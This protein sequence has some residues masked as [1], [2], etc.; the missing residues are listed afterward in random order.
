[1]NK[2][3]ILRYLIF[4]ILLLQ[5]VYGIA[6]EDISPPVLKNA[7]IM[8][9]EGDVRLTWYLTD[10][11]NSD[12]IIER[13]S[14]NINAFTEI[15]LIK[16]TSVTTWVDRN[17]NANNQSRAYRLGY[18]LE[19]QGVPSSNKFNTT[20]L[21]IDFDI[22]NKENNL[23]WSRYV[24]SSEI[25]NFNDTIQIKTWN[26]YRSIDGNNYTKIDS[27][28]NDTT[29][30][31]SNIEYDHIYKYYVEGVRDSDTSIKSKSNRVSI[32]TEMPEDPEYINF[33]KLET[34][35][36]GLDFEFTIARNSELNRYVLLGS[37]NLS[38]PYDT[39]ETFNTQENEI[40]YTDE[41]ID[42]QN[43]VY[44]YHM[45]S[46]NSC[47]ALTTR[48]DTL[49]NIMLSVEKENLS[50]ILEWNEMGHFSN[51]RYEISRRIG[52]Q[53]FRFHQTTYQSP[54]TDDNPEEFKGQDTSSRFCYQI[55]AEIQ[56]AQGLVSTITSNSKCIY[57]KPQIFIPNAII[58]NANNGNNAFKPEFTFVPQKYLL[59]V[60]SRN[61]TKVFESRNPRK[62]WIG[63]LRNGQKAPGGTYIYYLEVK[64]PGQPMIRKRGEVNVVY[65]K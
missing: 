20:Y 32:N 24:N 18:S 44:Y 23:I 34:Q 12:I 43:E 57:I 3:N 19:G 36:Q 45:A 42:P 1:M 39:V 5:T 55:K 25:I 7:S 22:C 33:D 37:N 50:S 47:G 35:E 30:T 2:A 48:S 52:E 56:H 49:G 21:E 26:V 29:F 54:Y 14:L 58:P 38:G 60:Y 27:I 28:S 51:I 65:Q 59:I 6:Q 63:R 61:G 4:I 11:I 64:N 9:E 10:T 46:V 13:D 17:S 8:N 41:S 62:P 40:A 15:H 31:D 53:P 16:D